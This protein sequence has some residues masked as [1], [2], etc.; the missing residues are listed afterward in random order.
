[1]ATQAQDPILTENQEVRQLK[2]GYKYGWSDVTNYV[3]AP[4]R[5]LSHEVID[6]I[7]DRKGEPDW[8]RAFRHKSL[9]YFLRR[10]MPKWGADL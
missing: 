8:M 2:E 6:Q 5:G 3:E 7:S 1:M 9:D 4:K 10:P